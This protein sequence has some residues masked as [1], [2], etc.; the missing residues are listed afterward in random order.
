MENQE[1]K[2]EVKMNATQAKDLLFTQQ[3]VEKLFVYLSN[4]PWK[5]VNELMGMIFAKINKS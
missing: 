4:Q 1:V 3:E 2:K 5:E